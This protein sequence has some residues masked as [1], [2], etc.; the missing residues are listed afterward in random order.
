MQTQGSG[1]TG[2]HKAFESATRAQRK[3]QHF[4]TGS[5]HIVAN[6]DLRVRPNTPL[7]LLGSVY[8]PHKAQET[9]RQPIDADTCR[10]QAAGAG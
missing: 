2:Y 4:S 3:L 1:P 5:W 10:G 8:L 9:H 6:L 7:P